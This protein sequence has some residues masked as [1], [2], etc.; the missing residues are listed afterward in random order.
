[1]HNAVEPDA[2]AP[3]VPIE[4]F[5]DVMST[6]IKKMV[7]TRLP[8]MVKYRPLE[9]SDLVQEANY[10]LLEAWTRDARRVASLDELCKIGNRAIHF[11]L[12]NL[13]LADRGRHSVKR[14][15][16]TPVQPQ[17][18]SPCRCAHRTKRGN[19]L[20][21]KQCCGRSDAAIVSMTVE[22]D[23]RRA[24]MDIAVNGDALER[25]LV[26]EALDIAVGPG[27]A[28]NLLIALAGGG[29]IDESDMEERRVL[30]E[31]QRK[32]V[33]LL[34]TPRGGGYNVVKPLTQREGDIMET[35]PQVPESPEELV[36]DAPVAVEAAASRPLTIKRSHKKKVAAAVKPVGAKK[37]KTAKTVKIPGTPRVPSAETKKLCA[38]FKA[39][40][41]VVYKGGS[42]AKWLK[43]G[44]SL[45]VK[46]TVSSRERTYLWLY[47]TNAKK[48]VALAPNFVEKKAS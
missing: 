48:L 42:R 22:N 35:V 12:G 17:P 43:T 32:L 41:T 33:K 44:T 26:R 39:G 45:L 47:A 10:A 34:H 1:M 23:G 4:Q 14:Q 24:A 7:L 2:P 40:E 9:Y 31:V 29:W 21:Y 19:K 37:P 16:Y 27:D 18:N 20:K 5:L 30:R 13:W 28:R 3:I 38:A 11:H 8:H 25:L 6:Y 36:Q 15:R 46:G